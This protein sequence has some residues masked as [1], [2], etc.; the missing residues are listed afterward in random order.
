MSRIG[1]E[2]LRTAASGDAP[3]VDDLLTRIG[4]GFFAEEVSDDD[5]ALLAIRRFD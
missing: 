3:T 5:T 1:M 2:R 4:D